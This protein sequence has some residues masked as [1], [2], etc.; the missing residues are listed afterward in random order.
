[1]FHPYQ[2]M[3]IEEST[4]KRMNYASVDRLVNDIS[5]EEL[6][7]LL[8]KQLKTEQFPELPKLLIPPYIEIARN[9]RAPVDMFQRMRTVVASLE[10]MDGHTVEEMPAAVRWDL[11]SDTNVLHLHKDYGGSSE[12]LADFVIHEVGHILSSYKNYLYRNNLD[13][14]QMVMPDVPQS[15]TLGMGEGFGE[16]LRAKYSTI[17]NRFPY[18]WQDGDYRQPIIG[19]PANVSQ[20]AADRK[21]AGIL[22]SNDPV[23]AYQVAPTILY[24]ADKKGKYGDLIRKYNAFVRAV[25]ADQSNWIFLASQFDESVNNMF[26]E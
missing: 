24:Y 25:D 2:G 3:T 21:I 20:L 9:Y 11:D 26:S 13:N 7:V 23:L 8:H 15:R 19:T 18:L 6:T 10:M 12:R 17:P 4:E 16:Y 5:D 22:T 14:D 1:M